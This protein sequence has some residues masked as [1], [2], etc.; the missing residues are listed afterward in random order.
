M[1]EADPKFQVELGEACN[2]ILACL[3]QR[4]G[5]FV[6]EYGSREVKIT[7]NPDGESWGLSTVEC[8]YVCKSGGLIPS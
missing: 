8:Y 1:L 2:D 6:Y 4:I 7:R 3:P 5:S